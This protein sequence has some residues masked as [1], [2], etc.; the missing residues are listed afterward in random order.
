MIIFKEEIADAFRL[1]VVQ[2]F[3][4][5]GASSFME[6]KEPDV[7]NTRFDGLYPKDPAKQ[8]I[9]TLLPPIGIRPI[10]ESLGADTFREA[11]EKVVPAYNKMQGRLIFILLVAALDDFLERH[12]FKG[13][14]GGRLQ[15]VL[16]L[17]PALLTEPILDDIHEIIQRRND[18]THNGG[19]VS[20]DYVTSKKYN[21]LAKSRWISQKGIPTRSVPH[22]FSQEYLYIAADAMYSFVK[23]IAVKGC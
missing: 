7:P 22:L 11:V 23:L 14:L 12:D 20:D 1:V 9:A 8:G 5:Q 19:R 2:C 13:T 17:Y 4:I 16:S 3:T 15:A 10:I 18:V 6:I 21:G